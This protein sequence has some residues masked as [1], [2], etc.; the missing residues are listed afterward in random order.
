MTILHDLYRH[1]NA[2]RRRVGRSGERPTQP[3]YVSDPTLLDPGD[4]HRPTSQEA[5]VAMEGRVAETAF[6]ADWT[7]M[8]FIHFEVDPDE[9][10]RVVPFSLDLFE[11]KAYVS[12]VAFTM[13][14]MRPAF[15]GKATEWITKPIA[16]H[17]FLNLRTYVNHRGRTGIFF[18]KEW[19]NERLAVMLGPKTFGL[20]YHYAKVDYLNDETHCAGRVVGE[21]GEVAYDGRKADYLT[22]ALPGTRDAFFLERYTAFT[23]AGR[24][25]Q[26]FRVWHQ[27]WKVGGING[28]TL[29]SKT[30]LGS[31]RERWTETAKLAGAHWSPGVFD[32]WMGRPHAVG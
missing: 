3:G 14:R 16:T 8:V 21:N 1:P 9:L 11:G 32:V 10:Q 2:K 6:L 12:L 22:P 5:R 23:N 26:F 31:L 19:L 30:L 17:Q 25:P 27:P 24:C 4:P 13:N 15:G 29:K 7:D 28:F 18:M 20:P